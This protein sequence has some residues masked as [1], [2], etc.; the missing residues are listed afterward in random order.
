[1][2]PDSPAPPTDQNEPPPERPNRAGRR[3]FRGSLFALGVVV[4]VAVLALMWAQVSLRSLSTESLAFSVA[5]R[6]QLFHLK[7]V[8]EIPDLSWAE[9]WNM[10]RVRGGFGLG[11]LVAEGRGLDGS[12]VNPFVTTHDVKAG[13]AI[14]QAR[15]AVCHGAEGGGWHAPQLT[16]GRLGHGDSD[17]SIYKILRDGIPGSA[18]SRQGLSLVERWQ[19][20][21]YIK[22][23]QRRESLEAEDARLMIRVAD[24]DLRA[25]NPEGWL[26]YSGTRDGQR[27]T[28]LNEITAEN[29][30][31][32]RVRWVRQF[33]SL[34][35]VFE[36]TPLAVN[37]VI[38]TTEPPSTAVALDGRTGDVLW[39]YERS[40]PG[41]LYLCCGRVNRG[42]AVFGN[43]V[44]LGSLDGFLIS[45]DA[46]SGRPVWEVQVADRSAGYSITGAP[47]IVNDTVIIGVG[48]GEFGTRGFLAAYDAFS[49]SQR[50]RFSTIPEPGQRGHETWENDAW[51]TGGGATWIT[52]SYDAALDLLYWGVGNPS[53]AYTGDVRPGDNLFTDSVVALNATTGKLVWHFQFTPHDEHDWD[54]NQTPILADLVI[55]GVT[56]K[57][58]CWANRN[59]FYYVLDR[60]TGEFLAGQAFVTVDWAKGL[61]A[62][63][64]PVLSDTVS[65][66]PGGRL[67]KPGVAGGTN[68]QNPSFDGTRG[69]VFVHATVDG[70]SIFTKSH[71]ARRGS[72]GFFLGSSGTTRVPPRIVVKALEA[73]TGR[74]VWEGAS[75]LPSEPRFSYGGLLSTGGGLIFGASNG[76]VFALNSDTGHELWRLSLGGETRAAPISFTLDGHQVVAVTVG[77]SMVL[78]S[79]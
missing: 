60:A 42:V 48:G 59:G 49:G 38:F 24:R 27:F 6:I 33:A 35:R 15:C 46:E 3:R 7:A 55:G 43:R 52:G 10:A 13:A 63:G 20:V 25:A 22:T 76:F 45:L 61:D 62:K 12:V 66:S 65:V 57:V 41:D 11:T 36:A 77:H 71:T 8:G 79:L 70:A 26:T 54:S 16:R 9:L 21:G 53:P 64:R 68:W 74:Q 28:P 75:Q 51:K 19:L 1:M 47:L 78:L 2:N 69:L 29:V 40:I 44:Y 14:F 39:R 73:S 56:R 17:M 72:L 23:L 18:M 34:D 67:T 32:L 50:W 58:V 30:S 31:Q 4:G 5:W 37:G